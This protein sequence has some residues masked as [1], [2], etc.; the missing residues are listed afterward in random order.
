M[1][2]GQPQ[3]HPAR[4]SLS[5]SRGHGYGPAPRTRPRLRP[6]C[7]TSCHRGVLDNRPSE[8]CHGQE[9]AAHLR[10]RPRCRSAVEEAALPGPRAPKGGS[11]SQPAG[12]RPPQLA[13]AGRPPPARSSGHHCITWRSTAHRCLCA[14]PRKAPCRRI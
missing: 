12:L 4:P 7:L 3:G 14:R 8:L 5:S 2:G 1:V 11:H 6:S 10:G 13:P 9:A